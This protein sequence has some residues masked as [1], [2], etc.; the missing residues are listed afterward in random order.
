MAPMPK[1]SKRKTNMAGSGF[2]WGIEVPFLRTT[3]Q[4]PKI[5][6]TLLDDSITH[7]EKQESKANATLISQNRGA[8]SNYRHAVFFVDS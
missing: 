2:L 8:P 3:G 1:I 4:S 7:S 6:I 5:F